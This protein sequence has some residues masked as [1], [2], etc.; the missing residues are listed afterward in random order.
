MDYWVILS[1]P[2]IRDLAEIAH[3]IA[4]DSPDAALRVGGELVTLAES[5]ATLPHRGGH[6]QAR[7]DVR[8]L[9]RETIA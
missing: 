1:R 9:V 6:L 7:P 2:A 4:Q 5:L 8:R 3:Y